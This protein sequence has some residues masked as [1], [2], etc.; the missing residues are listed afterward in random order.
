LQDLDVRALEED[1]LKKPEDRDHL[2]FKVLNTIQKNLTE[3]YADK[4]LI[5]DFKNFTA[6][7]VVEAEDKPDTVVFT[8]K[9]QNKEIDIN[10][11]D[12]IFSQS[13]SYNDFIDLV[14]DVTSVMAKTYDA[15]KLG[16]LAEIR[17]KAIAE[18]NRV[19]QT[20]DKILSYNTLAIDKEV[21][22]NQPGATPK[23]YEIFSDP[24]INAVRKRL[25]ITN[26]IYK[27]NE[28]NEIPFNTFLNVSYAKNYKNKIQEFYN[29]ATSAVTSGTGYA[30]FITFKDSEG[31]DL[32]KIKTTNKDN[33]LR[34]LETLNLL[35]LIELSKGID[36]NVKAD[37]AKLIIRNV[38]F[39]DVKDVR[40]LAQQTRLDAYKKLETKAVAELEAYKND[41]N[42]VGRSNYKFVL[43]RF[44]NQAEVYR[45]LQVEYKDIHSKLGINPKTDEGFELFYKE[46]LTDDNG[47]TA[48]SFFNNIIDT[49]S[50]KYV[51]GENGKGEIGLVRRAEVKTIQNKGEGIPLINNLLINHVFGKNSNVVRNKVLQRV[52]LDQSF[53]VIF[54]STWES[55]LRQRVE[56]MRKT[57]TTEE[58]INNKVPLNEKDLLTYITNYKEKTIPI[59]TEDGRAV[60]VIPD[61]KWSLKTMDEDRQTYKQILNGSK[62]NY[63]VLDVSILSETKYKEIEAIKNNNKDYANIDVYKVEDSVEFLPKF[64]NVQSSINRTIGS[65]AKGWLSDLD[66][67]TK[68]SN[69]EK[70]IEDLN[71][72]YKNLYSNKNL[73]GFV[74]VYKFYNEGIDL[75]NTT[76]FKE[77]EQEALFNVV[78]Y[79]FFEGF[80]YSNLE[81][82]KLGPIFLQ[83]KYL[84]KEYDINNLEKDVDP[85]DVAEYKKIKVWSKIVASLKNVKDKYENNIHIKN[86][87]YY[88]IMGEKHLNKLERLYN[89]VNDLLTYVET[90]RNK[91]YTELIP[92]IREHIDN[93]QPKIVTIS[94]VRNQLTAHNILNKPLT[95]GLSDTFDN[96]FDFKKRKELLDKFEV[97]AKNNLEK[98]QYYLNDLNNVIQEGAKNN[99]KIKDRVKNKNISIARIVSLKDLFI[100]FEQDKL[101]AKELYDK[102]KKY[103]PVQDVTKRVFKKIAENIFKNNPSGYKNADRIADNLMYGYVLKSYLVSIRQYMDRYPGDYFAQEA[104]MNYYEMLKRVIDISERQGIDKLDSYSLSLYKQALNLKKEVTDLPNKA[105]KYKFN[106]K[107]LKYISNDTQHLVYTKFKDA[108][109]IVDLVNNAKNIED[110]IDEITIDTYIV[111]YVKGKFGYELNDREKINLIEAAG[112]VIDAASGYLY[113]FKDEEIYTPRTSLVFND[114]NKLESI[115]LELK[116]KGFSDTQIK[117]IIRLGSKGSNDQ[118]VV[119]SSDEDFLKVFTDKDLIRKNFYREEIKEAAKKEQPKLENKLSYRKIF[120]IN[121]INLLENSEEFFKYFRKVIRPKD[122][123]PKKAI[124]AWDALGISEDEV[125]SLIKKDGYNDIE[126]FINSHVNIKTKETK[127]N[128]YKANLLML[129]IN[130]HKEKFIREQ[131]KTD[132]NPE[133]SNEDIKK[134]FEL[135][136]IKAKAN[137]IKLQTISINDL[138]GYGTSLTTGAKFQLNKGFENI[139]YIR[140]TNAFINDRLSNIILDDENLKAFDEYDIFYKGIYFKDNNVETI[141]RRHARNSYKHLYRD[142]NAGFVGEKTYE[143]MQLTKDAIVDIA[144][145]NNSPSWQVASG[146][147]VYN[148]LRKVWHDLIKEIKLDYVD[149]EFIKV[150]EI[151]AGIKTLMSS[152]ESINFF[153]NVY[154]KLV[155]DAKTEYIK[156]NG[157]VLDSTE[158]FKTDEVLV[159]EFNS[160]IKNALDQIKL[161]SEKNQSFII[162]NDD[163]IKAIFG[164]VWTARYS[165]SKKLTM[166]LSSF[167]NKQIQKRC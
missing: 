143:L 77:T 82:A 72:F 73:S 69:P 104:Y 71:I 87:D 25:T 46:L 45:K 116:N 32:F 94:N 144:V 137:N 150:R 51:P 146:K 1:F 113:A 95:K 156:N 24:V 128:F 68:H 89:I 80:D 6:M 10:V 125:M 142:Y 14:N 63:D 153:I 140:S 100:D 9:Q 59:I 109:E 147:V 149:R 60:I 11:F 93:A 108:G 112:T 135:E 55:E 121:R 33:Q 151:D 122:T 136:A 56:D 27:V 106:K 103:V 134:A 157:K 158:Q 165:D 130:Y 88:N 23:L 39:K 161:F 41:A 139:R 119:S 117:D 138:L 54:K 36:P 167:I 99:K 141:V 13:I 163:N 20:W 65:I 70:V 127:E 90:T 62:T 78:F 115:K 42:N 148:D 53:D 43:T 7:K 17:S 133:I 8:L 21:F 76:Q 61:N 26:S 160:V 29:T 52:Q 79:E 166:D 67:I 123:T 47:E 126:H 5:E 97:N 66:L 2:L 48:E 64:I 110:N 85:L 162:F 92:I 31:N 16:D 91:A 19:V 12:L 120:E 18:H 34:S 118:L 145:E 111:D 155:F 15:E 83:G 37:D 75:Y 86:L 132:N 4:Y 74:P 28:T 3:D 159:E 154:D 38:F 114:L 164:F 152:K 44:Q 30:P 40:G 107:H 84:T 49:D 105:K 98:Q 22:M 57:M 124:N 101:G 58:L 131:L 96:M 129:F 35:T 102:L 50:D 81:I